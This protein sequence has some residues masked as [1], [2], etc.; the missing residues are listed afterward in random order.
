MAF[1]GGTAKGFSL[2]LGSKSFIDGFEEGLVGTK[3]GDEKHLNLTFSKEYH[4]EDLAGA[5]VIFKVKSFSLIR[6][7]IKAGFYLFM[8]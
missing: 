1:E 8:I 3:A 7:I 2:K 6:H 4:A 5:D